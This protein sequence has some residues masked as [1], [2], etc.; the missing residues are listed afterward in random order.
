M[1][2]IL[3]AKTLAVVNDVAVPLGTASLGGDALFHFLVGGGTFTPD[4]SH[5]LLDLSSPDIPDDIYLVDAGSGAIAP[6]RRD[7]RPD[8]ASLPPIVTSSP[9]TML[10]KSWR[11]SSCTR[12]RTTDGCR[13]RK[14]TTWCAHSE[15]VAFRWSTWSPP[16]KGTAS[17]TG[18]T[19]WSFWPVW[20]DFSRV[21]CKLRI[22]AL[23]AAARWRAKA[24]NFNVPVIPGVSRCAGY[25]PALR[26]DLPHAKNLEGKAA[27]SVASFR[28]WHSLSAIRRHGRV[29]GRAHVGRRCVWL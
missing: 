26:N 21:R 6:L 10:T 23:I 18:R 4:G 22:P 20:C 9:I 29:V 15:N 13:A 5:F 12:V 3:D 1:V 28:I 7:Q 17:V 16:T 24:D 19:R 2:R 14:L 11:H 27:D 25:Y 8:L